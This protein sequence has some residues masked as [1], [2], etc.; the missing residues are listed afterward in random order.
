MLRTDT[1][2]ETDGGGPGAVQGL[3]TPD[4]VLNLDSRIYPYQAVLRAC[5]WLA[6]RA[7]FVVAQENGD[8]LRLAIRR[9]RPEDDIA[10]LL[11][12]LRTSLIDFALRVEIE[13]QTSN[14]REIIWRAA[15][16]EAGARRP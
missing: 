12:V 4:A 14:L 10:E 9:R 6:E 2:P 3:S 13:S 1:I 7:T 15:F 16:A 11:E 8:T 5:Y